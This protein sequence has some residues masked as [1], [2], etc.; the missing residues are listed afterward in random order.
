MN[1]FR[2]IFS[3]FSF[4][5]AATV[6]AQPAQSVEYSL[7][8]A[9]PYGAGTADVLGRNSEGVLVHMSGRSQDWMLCYSASTLDLKWK[10]EIALTEKSGSVEEAYLLGDSIVVLY[11]ANMRGNRVLKANLYS[12]RMSEL[13]DARELDT[14][15]AMSGEDAGF[16]FAVSPSHACAMVYNQPDE[17]NRK[18]EINFIV[19]NAALQTLRSGRVVANRFDV[20]ELVSGD[21]TDNGDA[22]F[23]CGD[24]K[25]RTYNNTYQY[26][27]VGVFAQT[28][29]GA[30]YSGVARENTLLGDPLFK[31][32]NANNAWVLSGLFADKPGNEAKGMYFGRGV[33]ADSAMLVR[34]FIPFTDEFL[35]NVT[36]QPGKRTRG[37]YDNVPTGLV[38][39]RDGGALFV[40]ETQTQYSENLTANRFTPMGGSGMITNH[41][42]FND[43]VV[44]SV[45]SAGA[46][47]WYQV[48]R[49][50]QQSDNDGGF[51]LS[52]GLLI[53]PRQLWLLYNDRVGGANNLSG[54]SVSGTGD[55]KRSILVDTDRKN[56]APV[57]SRA[58]QIAPDV[59]VIPSL[60]RGYFQLLKITFSS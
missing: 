38:V 47:Q 19:I 21:V 46:P 23:V 50:K 25:S 9:L 27:E 6:I 49:K 32:D 54:Y 53:G 34:Q 4:L 16:Q 29:S 1:P 55:N 56:L 33:P 2:L 17:F 7:P 41:F 30:F 5:S 44:F 36:G 52:Y 43:L 57:P 45:D 11:T 40:T 18:K 31:F 28:A 58:R 42:F 26:T 39:R 20:P 12:P 51:Y 15:H 24:N 22:Y 48:L 35:N 59:M 14:V 3:A 8:Q 60:R 13:R 37:F 10:K